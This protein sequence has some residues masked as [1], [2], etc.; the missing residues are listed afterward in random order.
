[1]LSRP[2]SRAR[3]EVKKS[4]VSRESGTESDGSEEEDAPNVHDEEFGNVSVLRLL[5]AL[6][7]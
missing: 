3:Q 4:R 2:G 1:V 6:L 5:P 7:E